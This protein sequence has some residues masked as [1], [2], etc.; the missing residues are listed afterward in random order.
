MPGGAR[1]VPGTC[2]APGAWRRGH[3]GG[4]ADTCRPASGPNDNFVAAAIVRDRKTLAATP[5]PAAN[6]K[7]VAL[8]DGHDHFTAPARRRPRA[9][10]LDCA[11]RRR[12]G[13][14]A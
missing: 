9:V 4:P 13:D 12:A 2:L 11:A 14:P 8:R 7:P 3:G 6:G 1:H 10:P 5:T